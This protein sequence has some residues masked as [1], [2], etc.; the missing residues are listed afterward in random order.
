MSTVTPF[1]EIKDAVLTVR[2]KL[3]HL[4]NFANMSSSL[5]L[6]FD[7][8]EDEEIPN[9]CLLEIMPFTSRDDSPKGLILIPCVTSSDITQYRRVGSFSCDKESEFARSCFEDCS[10][11]TLQIL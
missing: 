7:T 1:G 9:G 8:A 4:A 11:R 2:G 3:R 10:L 6:A 5:K